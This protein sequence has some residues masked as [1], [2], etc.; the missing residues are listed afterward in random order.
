MGV[1]RGF[2]AAVAATTMVLCAA[3]ARAGD[4]G[5][6]RPSALLFVGTDLWRDGAF[7]YG[8]LLWSPAGLDADGFTL[9]LILS[10]GGYA[11]PSAAL[12]ADVNGTLLSAAALPGWCLTRDGLTIALYAGPVVQDYRLTPNDPE[13]R[14][15][16][17]YVGGQFAADVWYEPNPA[18]MVALNGLVASIGPTGSLRAAVGWRLFEPFFV[19]PETQGIW[20][21]DYQQLRFGAHLTGWRVDA[22][23][24][25]AAGGWAL[26]SF[27]RGGPYV[28]FGVNARY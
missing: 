21:D 3:A 1:L 17:F 20:C 5:T 7:L 4:G 10:G 12:Q 9:K 15:R 24:W 16:G 14:L 8:G 11:Y 6:D 2:A 27:R 13:S 22:L 25:S 26:D 28:R 23:E 19:G 18:T